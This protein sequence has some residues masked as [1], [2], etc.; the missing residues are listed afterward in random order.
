MSVRAAVL[1]LTAPACHYCEDA[2]RVLGRLAEEF[3]LDVETRSIDD[4]AGRA[5]A[6]EHG[7]LFPPGIFIE[8][9]FLQYGRP[10]GRKIR[11]RL[12]AAGARRR[13]EARA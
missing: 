6:L 2:K 5:L 13:T 8:G 1:L 9:E 12:L 3:E 11:E 4:A 10:S 7:V